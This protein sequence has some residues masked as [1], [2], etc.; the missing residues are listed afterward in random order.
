VAKAYQWLSCNK[1]TV[2]HTSAFVGP[3]KTFI[4]LIN[5]QNMEHIKLRLTLIYHQLIAHEVVIIHLK[6]YTVQTPTCFSCPQPSSGIFK[7]RFSYTNGF[8]FCRNSSTSA[9]HSKYWRY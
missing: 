8:L 5:A 9:V 7:E 6:H 4:H 3:F 2:I 1:I